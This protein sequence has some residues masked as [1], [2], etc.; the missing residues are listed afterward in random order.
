MGTGNRSTSRI[1]QQAVFDV[2]RP[3]VWILRTCGISERSFRSATD[4][5]CRQYARSSTRAVKFEHAPFLKAAEILMVW[6]R[7]PD[8]IDETGSPMKLPLRGGRHSFEGLLKKAGVSMPV[9]SA[10]K[11][12]QRLGSVQRSRRQVRLVSNVLL[13]VNGN[14]FVAGPVLE[15][16]RGFVETIEHNL[17][18]R[19]NPA[20]GRMN[21]LACCAALDPAQF[22][23]VQRFVRSGSQAFL[24]ALDEKL[25]SCKARDGKGPYYGA[26]I[27]V[28]VR[29]SAKPARQH[30]RKRTA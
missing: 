2:V 9:H 27:Y 15:N 28:V 18:Q 8:F 16:I 29:G 13:S 19:Q 22:A 25:E 5:A 24:D 10:L 7:D 3:F 4:K 21:R 11:Q 26:G 1:P 6:A 14:Q 17:Y 30:K 20:E 12:L 23:E